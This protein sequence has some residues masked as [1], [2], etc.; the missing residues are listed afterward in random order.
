MGHASWAIGLWCVVV[1]ASC[2]ASM[3][4]TDHGMGRVTDA[5]GGAGGGASSDAGALGRDAG[6]RVD[7]GEPCSLGATR[8]CY[9]A[10]PTTL[11]AGACHAGTESCVPNGEFAVWGGTCAGFVGP[12]VEDCGDSRT[13]N[14][15]DED[16]DGTVD[17]DCCTLTTYARSTGFTASGSM[18]CCDADHTASAVVDCGDGSNHWASPSGTACG[19]AYEGDGNRGGPC[20]QI[21]CTGLICPG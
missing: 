17:E 12:G 1:V 2:D 6:A 20:V 16:C 13:G 8:E 10:D 19:I 5:D 9:P 4:T 3:G 14:G 18:I 21:T 7:A 11:G 15:I